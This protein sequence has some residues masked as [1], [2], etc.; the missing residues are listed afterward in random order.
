MV[1]IGSGVSQGAEIE[2]MIADLQLAKQ[3]ELDLLREKLTKNY[4]EEINKLS[5]VQGAQMESV[6]REKDEE[7]ARVKAN[8]AKW[9]EETAAK[10][11]AAM[12]DEFRAEWER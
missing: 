12:H 7:M 10:I 2:K 5:R 11:A 1:S 3:R 9:K 6:L 4:T 8:L